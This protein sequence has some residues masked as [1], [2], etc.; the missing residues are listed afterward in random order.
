MNCYG[1][2]NGYKIV[3]GDWC[4]RMVD[5]KGFPMEL[6]VMECKERGWIPYW[7]E[8]LQAA[9]KSGWSDKTIFSKFSECK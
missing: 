1:E 6:M 8:F 3:G 4:F 2:W 7:P 9:I 5:E